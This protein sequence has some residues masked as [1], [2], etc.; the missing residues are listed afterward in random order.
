MPKP[1][2]QTKLEP[3]K[4]QPKK[5]TTKQVDEIKENLK[6]DQF[7]DTIR[8]DLIKIIKDDVENGE[9]AQVQYIAQKVKDLQHYHS[10]KP[11]KIEALDKLSWMSDRNLGLARAIADIYQAVLLATCWNPDSINFV[12]TKTSDVNNRDNQV[13][14]TKWGMGKHEANAKPEVDDFIH[15]R[16]IVGGSFAKIYRKTWD[17]WVDSR[18]PKKR[19]SGETYAYD[20]KTAKKPFTKGVIEN[21]DNIDDILIPEYGKKIQEL[22][23]FIQRLHLDGEEVL[24]NIDKKVFIPV[25]VEEYKKKL[26]THAWKKKESEIEKERRDQL[27]ITEVS[28]TDL[29]VRRLRITVYEWYGYYTINKRR[30][31]FRI[32]VDLENEEFLSGKPVREINRSGKIPFVGGSLM[33]EPGQIRGDSLM[34]LI[35]SLINAFNNI[36]N[37]KSD[38]QYVTNCPFGFHVPDEGYTKQVYELEPMKSYP[39]SGPE[40]SKGVYFPNLSRSMAWAEADIRILFEVLE[41]LTG[42]ASY[43]LTTQTKQGTLGRDIMVEEKGETKFGL[44]VGRIQEDIS[45]AISMWFELYQDF[46]PKNLAE[47]ILGE[48]GKQIFRNLSIDSLRGD[49]DVQMTPDPVAGSKAFRRQLQL[50]IFQMGQNMIWLHPQ[51]NPKGNWNFCADMFKGIAGMTE[52]EIKRYLGP[53]P[54]SEFDEAEL[55][56]EWNRFMNGEDFKPPEGE[57]ALS[58]QHLKGHMKQKAEKY[59]KLD[60]EY[61]PNFDSHL[62]ITMVNFQKFMANAQRDIVVNRMASNEI[63]MRDQMGG[64]GGAPAR[65]PTGPMGPQGQPPAPGGMT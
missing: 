52:T 15:N 36:Y 40:A 19:K 62:F 30:E 24:N 7:S 58:L 65:G 20:I 21:I 60:E 13:K 41:R 28:I 6:S 35:A 5:T 8:K 37:Q 49:A 51:V 16:I 11:S 32:R 54:K 26:R 39:V 53:E 10:E 14:F 59:D 18:I 29:D 9:K 25:N 55:D 1:N 23:F 27:G 50:H 47:R 48:D 42:A 61:R 57:T 44:W 22:P 34:K 43:F 46:P 33:K 31:R 4:E 45:E 56:N 64:N 2:K 17:E 3:K 12:A 38:F 63:M